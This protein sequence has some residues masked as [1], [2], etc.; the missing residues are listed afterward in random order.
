VPQTILNPPIS[1]I[2]SEPSSS[3]LHIS[4]TILNSPTT[5]IKPPLITLIT[6]SISN[7][8]ILENESLS[9]LNFMNNN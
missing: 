5:F 6:P 9:L 4:S 8:P 7:Q 2:N 1:E 3:F